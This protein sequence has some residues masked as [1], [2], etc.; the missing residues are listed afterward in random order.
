MRLAPTLALAA[1]LVGCSATPDA[2]APTTAAETAPSQ[3][4][5]PT[6]TQEPTPEP[7]PTPTP[8]PTPKAE[9]PV[10]ASWQVPGTFLS[11]LRGTDSAAVAYFIED[12]HL[13]IGAWDAAGTELW[14]AKA[15]PS[16]TAGGVTVIPRVVDDSVA[17]LQEMRDNGY[18]TVRLA[19][20]SSG[21]E[22]GTSEEIWA[23]SRPLSCGDGEGICVDGYLAADG[24]DAELA[25]FRVSEDG[26][27]APSEADFLPEGSRALG[28]GV[29]ST[30]VRPWGTGQW[31]GTEMLGYQ[32]GGGQAWERPYMEVF[33]EGFS[34]DGGWE[35]R[36]DVAPAVLGTGYHF[37]R[38]QTGSRDLTRSVVVAL[39][40]ATGETLW[41]VPGAS[42]C[43]SSEDE[44]N[45]V[46][47]CVNS[48]G[49][50]QFAEGQDTV[51]TDMVSELR[52]VDPATGETMWTVP[53][54]AANYTHEWW[55]E[56]FL[57]PEDTL[58]RFVDGVVTEIDLVTGETVPLPTGT[59]ACTTLRDAIKVVDSGERGD[60]GIG[61]AVT[62]CGVDGVP[63]ESFSQAAV[64][65]AGLRVGDTWM[66]VIEAGL[67]GFPAVA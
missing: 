66:L 27:L 5:S 40:R 46:V 44:S 56:P 67:T 18:T 4:A 49:V 36:T 19:K 41:S 58:V 32:E 64:E 35:W 22:L 42:F 9:I 10:S 53:L 61:P 47:L 30:N 6:P 25:R 60:Q 1:L 29:Y 48:P 54:D 37:E 12:R 24:P 28:T 21:E 31:Q 16:R 20:V 62:P 23:T 3:T 57:S 45:L 13:S 39:D 11:V 52:R 33:G 50:A 34:S 15:D 59:L 51:F 7:S 63:T 65:A 43:N 17:Y 55:G 8:T 2:P 38:E 14:R 26:S